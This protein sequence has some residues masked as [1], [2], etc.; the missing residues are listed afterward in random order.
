M[1]LCGGSHGLRPLNDGELWVSASTVGH[2]RLR[3]G[4]HG[5]LRTPLNPQPPASDANPAERIASEK[6]EQGS[7]RSFCRK[8][9]AELSILCDDAGAGQ[10]IIVIP[11]EPTGGFP[12][13]ARE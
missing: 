11:V 1:R 8:A 9:E 6:E 10:Y 13:G 5:V 3:G 4:F 7:G 2:V 12:R